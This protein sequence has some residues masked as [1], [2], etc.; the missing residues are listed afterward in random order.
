MPR[1][2]DDFRETFQ[3]K[4]FKIMA[5]FIDGFHFLADLKK[6]ITI[7]GSTSFV[8]KNRYYEEARKLGWLLA[9][10]GFTVIT[11]GGPG[12]MEAANKGAF[13]AKGESVGINIQLPEGQRMN[14]YVTKPIGFNYF[15]VRKVMLSFSSQA[16]V[17]F[18]GGF[19]TLDEFFEMVTLVQ[20]KKLAKP[21][22]VIAVGKDYWR[23]LFGWL[24]SEVYLK[25]KSVKAENLKIFQLVDSAKETYQLIKNIK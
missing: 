12:I 3:W 21:V 23:N 19:G 22:P 9:K 16:Y 4:I 24:E 20:T 6:T 11:G 5:E 2:K 18:P 14:K 25:Q 13:E 1:V 7:F 10:A 8:P 17:F 15:F